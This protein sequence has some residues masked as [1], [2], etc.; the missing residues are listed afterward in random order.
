MMHV[1]DWLPT[2]LHATGYDV[3][4]LK[5]T[6]DKSLDGID[7]WET[8]SMNNESR[9]TEILLNIDPIAKS[10]GIRMGDMK[11]IKG[12]DYVGWDKWYPPE[13]VQQPG[14]YSAEF[15]EKYTNLRLILQKSGI[16]NSSYSSRNPT[17][18]PASVNCEPTHYTACNLSSN[19]PCLFN[20][21]TDP[22]EYN[23][24]AITHPETV[25][26]LQ[27]RLD[28]YRAGMVPPRNQP[29]DPKGLPVHHKGAWVPW[30]E[31]AADGT[32]S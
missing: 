14:R 3:N 15:H 22:C 32:L 27:A 16:S 11:L 4:T 12:V 18:V 1:T 26:L 6:S 20:I 31:L 2:I 13:G 10:E 24:L 17:I 5:Q 8:L 7:Q 23:N 30:V 19:M 25:R 9:R 29:Q 21:K 28:Q